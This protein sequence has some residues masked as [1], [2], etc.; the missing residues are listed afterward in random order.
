M[1]RV[2]TRSSTIQTVTI[3][4]VEPSRLLV[5]RSVGRSGANRGMLSV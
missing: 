5:G 4:A 1:T 2:R 3:P